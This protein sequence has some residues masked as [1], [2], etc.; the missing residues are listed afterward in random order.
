V[1]DS[2]LVHV[3]ERAGD[4]INVLPDALLWKGDILFDVALHD[5]LQVALLSPLNSDE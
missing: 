4:L 5:L 1:H 3:L 2:L